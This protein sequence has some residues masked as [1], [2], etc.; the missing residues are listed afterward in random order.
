MEEH[1]SKT[2]SVLQHVF[3]ISHW[4]AIQKLI[5]FPKKRDRYTFLF[6]IIIDYAMNIIAE[7]IATFTKIKFN[8]DF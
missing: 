7:T 3:L 4:L 5:I 1:Y 6:W 8:N 2:R